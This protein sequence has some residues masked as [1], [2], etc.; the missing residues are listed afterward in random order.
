MGTNLPFPAPRLTLR[1]VPLVSSRAASLRSLPSCRYRPSSRS[2]LPG[3]PG[4]RSTSRTSSLA[5]LASEFGLRRPPR[6]ASLPKKEAGCGPPGNRGRRAS[7]RRAVTEATVADDRGRRNPGGTFP[8]GRSR[9]GTH[10]G[11]SRCGRLPEGRLAIGR[12]RW[13][14]DRGSGR[15]VPSRRSAVPAEAGIGRRGPCQ[16]AVPAEAGIGMAGFGVSRACRS[17]LGGSD[18][19][20]GACRSRS[21]GPGRV[22]AAT[23][24]FPV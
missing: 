8:V 3:C 24:G 21:V 14:V 23:Q 15:L 22:C 12:S 6:A 9:W 16:S 10:I 17:K 13:S 5:Y 11:R 20:L 2:D 4:L 19:V 7:P 18:R 1:R